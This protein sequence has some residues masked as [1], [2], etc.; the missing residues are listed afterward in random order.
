MKK[1]T[2]SALLTAL[3]IC[4]TIAIIVVIIRIQMRG[5]AAVEPVD[6]ESYIV[7]EDTG[8][9]NSVPE[10]EPEE[11]STAVTEL[12]AVPNTSTSVNVRSGPGTE[13]N[14]LGSAY[15]N[16][17]Y[18]VLEILSVGWTK[19]LYSDQE[20]YIHNDYVDYKVRI[21]DGDNVSYETANEDVLAGYMSEE[22][23][24]SGVSEEPVEGTEAESQGVEEPTE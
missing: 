3:M 13:Y 8:S 18:V 19:I 5:P 16:N 17:E 22:V 23:P 10:E 7:Q 20:A 6:S 1:Q 11:V 2:I 24:A 14:R 12:V 4:L 15:S 9:Q 21:T